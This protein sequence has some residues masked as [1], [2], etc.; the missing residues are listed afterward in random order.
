MAS[1]DV[2]SLFTNIPLDFAIDLVLQKIYSD[3]GVTLFY[4]FNKTQFKGC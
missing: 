3:S 1:F 2:V 4:G